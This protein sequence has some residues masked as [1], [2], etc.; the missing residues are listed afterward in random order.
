MVNLRKARYE[1]KHAIINISKHVWEGN[2]YLPEIF[3][4]WVEDKNGEF[5][6]AEIDG[7]VVGCAKFTVL[8]DKEYWLEGIRV[9]IKTRGQGIGKR[10]TEYYV[11]KSKKM[12]FK[13]LRLSTY[14][15]NHE[16]LKI[17]NRY[18][19]K[20][21]IGF[22]IFSL[23]EKI[24]NNNVLDYEKANNI[25]EIRYILDTYEMKKREENLAFDWTF[26]KAKESLLEELIEKGSI[27]IFK[28]DGYVK[29]T[30][31]I[32]DKH[33]KSNELSISYIDGKEYYEEGIKFAIKKYLEGDYRGLTFMCPDIEDMKTSACEAGLINWDDSKEDVFVFEYFGDNN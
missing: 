29:S 25:D 12:G 20:K 28:K 11:D 26:I 2:D 1:D 13:N 19:F 15:E 3:D 33:S 18:G 17:I 5:T 24:N 8:E 6:I 23:E 31:I 22:K 27:Y 21:T 30:V 14:I 16:S 32:S 4:K 9:D 10:I 7:K